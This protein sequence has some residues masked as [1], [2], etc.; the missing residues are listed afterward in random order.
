MLSP[1]VYMADRRENVRV[2]QDG[3]GHANA[4]NTVRYTT[5]ARG[6]RWAWRS[7]RAAR[8]ARMRRHR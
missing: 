6:R 4:Q 8:A 3:L 7:M 5:L 2:M 1:E